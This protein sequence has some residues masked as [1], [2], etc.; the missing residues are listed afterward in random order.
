MREKRVLALNRSWQPVNV[1]SLRRA[2]ALL[3]MGHVQ[4]VA[5]EEGSFRTCGFEAWKEFSREQG[6]GRPLIH[7]VSFSLLVPEVILLLEYDRMPRR[8]V[9]LT[10]K[11]VYERDGNRCQ[12]CGRT[13]EDREL[14][15]DH[16]IP[17][18]RGGK[19]TWTNVVCSCHECNGR[20]GN[21]IL[22]EARM[23]LVRRP[24]RPH[25]QPFLLPR[26]GQVR[27][28]S[29]KHFLDPSYWKAELGEEARELEYAWKP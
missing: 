17:V 7:T 6:D 24:R 23:T 18:A 16:V 4:V 1:C 25:W 13:F 14:N 26:C 19:T 3:Y 22:P 8:E 29:W 2:L 5:G 15:L 12:Y 20:K 9:K 10:R 27:R 21:H 28:E 11:N